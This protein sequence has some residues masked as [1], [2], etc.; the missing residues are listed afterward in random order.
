MR[1]KPSLFCLGPSG[2][3]SYPVIH[4]RCP[5]GVTWADVMA[6]LVQP[7]V[8]AALPSQETLCSLLVCSHL[9]LLVLKSLS[10]P[11]GA[12]ARLPPRGSGCLL[13]NMNSARRAVCHVAVAIC[14]LHSVWVGACLQA[15]RSHHFSL[16]TFS[17]SSL[18]HHELPTSGAAQPPLHCH[19]CP[20]DLHTHPHSDQRTPGLG[21]SCALVTL[22]RAWAPRDLVKLH[23]RSGARLCISHKFSGDPVLLAHGPYFENYCSDFPGFRYLH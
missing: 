7:P 21:L 13:W 11:G 8:P 19:L 12:G 10:R 5:T 2:A 1:V 6:G 22:Q 14:S 23:S 18:I 17:G 16:V 20:S 4:Q 15:R 9:K 3:C